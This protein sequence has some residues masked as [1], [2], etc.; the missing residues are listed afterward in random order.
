MYVVFVID[1]I[2]LDGGKIELVRPS[3]SCL[4]TLAT[5][6]VLSDR[7]HKFNIIVQIKQIFGRQKLQLTVKQIS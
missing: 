1:E 5:T 6:G 2:L 4:D 3:E 7:C